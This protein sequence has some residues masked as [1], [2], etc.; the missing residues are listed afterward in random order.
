MTEA[1]NDAVP[2]IGPATEARLRIAFA[3]TLLL[4]AKATARLLGMDEGTLRAMAEAGYITCVRRG[5]GSIRAY[6]EGDIRMYLTQGD[7]P[8][9]KEK[10]RATV[11][12][13]NKVVPFSQRKRGGR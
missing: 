10:P 11:H 2:T 12:V 8:A 6:R 7:A 5:A 3:D 9:R 1:A 4:T 13:S